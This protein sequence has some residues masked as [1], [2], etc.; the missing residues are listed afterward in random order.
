MG[1]LFKQIKQRTDHNL[2]TRL[3]TL[4]LTHM[5]F[6]GL[7]FWRQV[8]FEDDCKISNISPND[9]LTYSSVEKPGRLFVS[10]HSM[11]VSYA[12]LGGLKNF[13]DSILIAI[14]AVF[15]F[16]APP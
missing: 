16:A 8:S 12:T 4:S 15:F 3:P 13:H 11:D 7:L 14:L 1:R 2:L 6:N 9:V 5:W 10:P